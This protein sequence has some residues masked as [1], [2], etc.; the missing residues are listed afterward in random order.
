MIGAGVE[1]AWA[2]LPAGR[3]NFAIQSFFY[4]GTI[5][6]NKIVPLC[7]ESPLSANGF[8]VRLRIYPDYFCRNCFNQRRWYCARLPFVEVDYCI[9][10][11]KVTDDKCNHA[12]QYFTSGRHRSPKQGSIRCPTAHRPRASE[13]CSANRPPL[14]CHSCRRHRRRLR[15]V[16]SSPSRTR[17]RP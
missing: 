7:S 1:P 14:C 13:G 11:Q 2:Y 4:K 17:W 6:V 12:T 8:I 3:Q 10:G 16:R 5:A 9:C 15:H